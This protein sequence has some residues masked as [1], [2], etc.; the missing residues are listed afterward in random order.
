MAVERSRTQCQGAQKA[1]V[2]EPWPGHLDAACWVRGWH[3]RNLGFWSGET[4]HRGLPLL[5]SPLDQHPCAPQI[6]CGKMKRGLL[7]HRTTV[8]QNCL[9]SG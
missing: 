1:G 7:N 2:R 5:P 4:P 8:I 6:A 9:K 3:V